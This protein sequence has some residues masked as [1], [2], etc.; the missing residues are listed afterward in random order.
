[1]ALVRGKLEGVSVSKFVRVAEL[2]ST[3]LTRA[4][5]ADGF[6]PQSE[7]FARITFS[8]QLEECLQKDGNINEAE[9]CRLV[10]NWNS[11]NDEPGISV[12]QRIK[13]RL[14]CR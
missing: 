9:F 14:E 2:G 8:E 1:M 13:L 3:P 5:I 12:L 10:R 7:D 11:A 6:E 4:I